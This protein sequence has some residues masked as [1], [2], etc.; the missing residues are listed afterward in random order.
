M[1]NFLILLM[2]FVSLTMSKE[3]KINEIYKSVQ[4]SN[5]AVLEEE[6]KTFCEV[7]NDTAKN[8]LD[9]FIKCQID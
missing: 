5:E 2:A 7:Y 8:N 9:A 4:N 3:I 1:K 6:A